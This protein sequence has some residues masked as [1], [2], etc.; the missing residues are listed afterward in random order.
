M[1]DVAESTPAIVRNKSTKRTAS[2][3]ASDAKPATATMETK[4]RATTMLP[5]TYLVTHIPPP[6]DGTYNRTAVAVA[7]DRDR[8]VDAVASIL[9]PGTDLGDVSVHEVDLTKPFVYDME[10]NLLSVPPPDEDAASS[11]QEKMSV[12]V[13]FDY[14][15]TFSI[16]P[17]VAVIVAGNKPH[18]DLLLGAYV[19]SFNCD[20]APHDTHLIDTS[21]HGYAMLLAPGKVP[22]IRGSR[23][24]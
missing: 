23:R 9:S 7:V 15:A 17:T 22:P 24:V 14:N 11:V 13:A 6:P 3:A 10:M 21:Q 16:M 8:A 19:G 2:A 20:V 1:T 5:N 4:K 12:F 18:A